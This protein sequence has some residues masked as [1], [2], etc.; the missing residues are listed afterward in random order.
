M[1]EMRVRLLAG[2]KRH[3]VAKRLAGLLSVEGLRI[4]QY[5]CD[6]ASDKPENPLRLWAS[7]EKEVNGGWLVRGASRILLITTRAYR[8]LRP[9]MQ[10]VCSWPYQKIAGLLRRFLGRKMLVSCEVAVEYY[11]ALL[12]SPQIQWLKGHGESCWRLLEEVESENDAAYH[13]IIEREIEAP[14]RFQ[15]IQSYRAAMAILRQQ[16]LFVQELF[17]TGMVDETEE[18]GLCDPIDKKLRHLELVGPVWRP[19]RPRQVL[20]SL[21]FMAN[22]PDT[23]FRKLYDSGTFTEFRKGQC[24]WTATDLVRRTGGIQG[25]GGFVVLSGVVKRVHIRPD[26][27]R[28]E[29][30][31]GTGGVL[32]ILLALTGTK[33]PG[34]DLAIAEGNALGKGPLV[35]HFPQKAVREIQSSAELGDAHMANLEEELCR[36]SAAYVVESMEAELVGTMSQHIKNVLSVQAQGRLGTGEQLHRSGSAPV[37]APRRT[38]SDAALGSTLSHEGSGMFSALSRHSTVAGLGAPLGPSSAGTGL[39]T[40][41]SVGANLAAMMQQIAAMEYE[42][43]EEE[44]DSEGSEDGR[45]ERTSTAANGSALSLHTQ[46]QIRDSVRRSG[47]FDVEMGAMI[48]HTR[49]REDADRSPSRSPRRGVRFSE[50]AGGH[51]HHHLGPEG[52]A[53][54]IISHALLRAPQLAADASMD[55]RRALHSSFVLRLEGGSGFDQTSHM[56]LLSGTLTRTGIIPRSATDSSDALISAP[57]VLPWLWQDRWVSGVGSHMGMVESVEWHVGHLGAILVLAHNADGAVPDA[58]I[59]WEERVQEITMEKARKAAI[60]VTSYPLHVSND[61]LQGGMKRSSS[62]SGS[63]QGSLTG[64][65]AALMKDQLAGI[66]GLLRR[67]SAD[68]RTSPAQK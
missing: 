24:I 33:L 51:Q 52:D 61:G 56:V 47:E 36:L 59:E 60:T 9:T 8:A 18:R 12:W 48:E 3:F 67:P 54:T 13:F 20:R 62:A 6:V 58:V 44:S 31:Q 23:V 25:P 17:E 26:G 45:K 65:S 5:V 57:A 21:P 53:K 50:P 55:I 40:S 68:V 46:Q 28:K 22:L 39:V 41:K 34:T 29:Y 30:F 4:L 27:A 15:A 37:Q 19:P 10:R 63:E 1:A 11:L 16:L 43:D 7:I 42:E 2:L 66:M 14:D 64:R 35:F 49:T 32:G 38:T